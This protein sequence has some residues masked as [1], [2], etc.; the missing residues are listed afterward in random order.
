M[1]LPS[2]PFLFTSTRIFTSG[3]SPKE[4]EASLKKLGSSWRQIESRDAIMKT[5]QFRDFSEAWSF[6]SRVALIAEQMN[7]HPEWFNVYNRVEVTLTTHDTG[8]VSQKDI[9]MALKM[10]EFASQINRST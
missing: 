5:F 4:R 1:R 6:M 8:G 10:D 7:H 9:D 2:R 3:F